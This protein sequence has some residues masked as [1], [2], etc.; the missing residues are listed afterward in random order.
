MECPYCTADLPDENLFCEEC[1]KPLTQQPAEPRCAC[2]A[3]LADADEEGFCNTC[4]RRVR[5]RETDHIELEISPDFAAVSDKGI[6]HD[7]NEDRF[8]IRQNET[9]T[10]LVVCDGVSSSHESEQASALASETIATMLEDSAELNEAMAEAA[11]K[12]A[13]LGSQG[14][15]DAP[16][17]TA[18]AARVRGTEVTLAWVGDSRAYWLDAE[19]ATQLTNDHSWMNSVVAAGQMTAEQASKESRAHAITRWFGADAIDESQAEITTFEIPGEGFLLL[20]TDG[21][22]NYAQELSELNQLLPRT[23]TALEACR[24]LVDF[25][26]SKGGQDNITTA[27]LRVAASSNSTTKGL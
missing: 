10:I 2:G 20:C 3:P 5:P 19:G 25:A 24:H 8:A 9:Q 15:S 13:A 12:V 6:R 4:G 7:R 11:V 27:L 18:V 1:G 21:L 17:T 16:S 26:N 22:W 23:G 14:G